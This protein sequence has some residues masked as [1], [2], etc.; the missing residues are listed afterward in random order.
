MQRYQIEMIVGIYGCLRISEL[1][2]I[3][4][5]DVVNEE[6]AIKIH[7]HRDKSS[8]SLPKPLHWIL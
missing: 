4:W 7:V 8:T 1:S 6:N 2:N 3:Q 5:R